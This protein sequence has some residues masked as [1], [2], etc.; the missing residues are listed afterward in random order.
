[1]SEV[2][3][4]FTIKVNIADRYYPIKIKRIDEAK[5]RNAAKRIN[6]M[7]LQYRKIYSEKDSQ[8]FL[9]MAAL[10]LVTRLSEIEDDNGGQKYREA[11]DEINDKLTTALNKE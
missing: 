4:T 1:M 2:N 9:A 11:L 8:D 5:V 6:D 10:Q 7:V 3:E